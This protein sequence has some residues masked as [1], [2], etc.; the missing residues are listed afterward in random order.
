MQRSIKLL[1]ATALA[2]SF[3][4]PFSASALGTSFG[5]RVVAAVPCLSPLGPSIWFTVV[6]AS[7]YPVINFIWTPATVTYLAGPVNHIGQQVLGVADIPYACKVGT[8]PFFGQR[9]QIEGT[10]AI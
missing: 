5:G 9:V 4:A 2:A 6:P 8:I 3:L 10:S 1:A 7:F